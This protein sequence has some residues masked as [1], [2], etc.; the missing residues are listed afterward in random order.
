VKLW[1]YLIFNLTVNAWFTMLCEGALANHF[2]WPTIS[3]WQ[4]V[5]FLLG[6]GSVVSYALVLYNYKYLFGWKL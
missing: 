5:L 1:A 4:A 3:Y 2:G 6:V